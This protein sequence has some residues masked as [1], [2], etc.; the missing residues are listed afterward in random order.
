M[1]FGSVDLEEEGG[2]AEEPRAHDADGRTYP[3][4]GDDGDWLSLDARQEPGEAAAADAAGEAPAAQDDQAWMDGTAAEALTGAAGAT[5]EPEDAH[6]FVDHAAD[7]GH[8][9]DA[10]MVTE[11]MAELYAAQGMPERAA[12]VYREL[13]QQRGE[14]PALV[15]RLDELEAQM[16]AADDDGVGVT[17]EPAEGSGLPAD[18][19]NAADGDDGSWLATVDAYA[20]DEPEEGAVPVDAGGEVPSYGSDAVD[21][22]ADR[23]REDEA[24]AEAY[25]SNAEPAF[26]AAAG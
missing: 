4:A 22:G 9:H 12:D 1:G 7:H 16:R 14:T 23:D 19:G 13:I 11:T 21:L 18:G 6:G 5:P 20:R 25:T 24:A 10:E 17:M 8:G 3:D 2:E 15:R 26:A